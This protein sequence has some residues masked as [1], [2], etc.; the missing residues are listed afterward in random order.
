M[1]NYLSNGLLWLWFFGALLLGI[2]IAYGVIRTGRLSG[3]ERQ[4]L[5]EATELRQRADDPM[6]R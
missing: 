3:E 5:N 2:V 6:K 1:M 4:R